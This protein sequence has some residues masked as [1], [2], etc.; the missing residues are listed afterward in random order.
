MKSIAVDVLGVLL[1]IAAALTGWLPGPGGIPLLIIGLSLLATNH[2]WAERWLN[3]VK[4]GGD[5]IGNKLFNGSPITT[6]AIDIAAVLLIAGAVL[7]VN[8][9]TA[10]VARSAA[11]S[12]AALSLVLLL[13]N[14]NRLTALKKRFKK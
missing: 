3:K 9:F 6:W 13:G 12:L 4:H 8:H 14:R 7:I 5:Q 1:I 10:N 11:I 2:E